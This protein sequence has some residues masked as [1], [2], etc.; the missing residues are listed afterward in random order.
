M[1]EFAKKKFHRPKK[2]TRS[3]REINFLLAYDDFFQLLSR[4]RALVN[5][6]AI[7]YHGTPVMINGLIRIGAPYHGTLVTALESLLSIAS[8]VEDVKLL[9]DYTLIIIVCFEI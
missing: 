2:I 9:A 7:Y 1:V 4:K 6:T 8:V 5:E 3:E